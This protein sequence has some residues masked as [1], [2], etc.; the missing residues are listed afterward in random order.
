MEM[1]GVKRAATWRWEE[2]EWGVLVRKEG[3]HPLHR[4][5]YRTLSD[6]SASGFSG[7]VLVNSAGSIAYVSLW[8]DNPM[9]VTWLRTWP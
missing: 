1:E 8:F 6:N 2:S 7:S 4:N 5:I 3:V 9:R